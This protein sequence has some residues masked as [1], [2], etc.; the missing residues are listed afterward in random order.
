MAFSVSEKSQVKEEKDKEVQEMGK[1]PACGPCS[2]EGTTQG[3]A[4]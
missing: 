1:F 2:S 3:R 4:K